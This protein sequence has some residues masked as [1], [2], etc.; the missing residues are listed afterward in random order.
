MET[1]AT[2]RI[3]QATESGMI[4]LMNVEKNEIF[5]M[6]SSLKKGKREKKIIVY[7]N[8]E[9]EVPNASGVEPLVVFRS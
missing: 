8:V 3:Q 5:F 9:S 4:D 6:F 2:R 1:K 7:R